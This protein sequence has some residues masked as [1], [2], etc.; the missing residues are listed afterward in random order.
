L[1]SPKS[2]GRRSTIIIIMRATLHDPAPNTYYEHWLG[3]KAA[4]SGPRIVGHCP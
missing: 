3:G 2:D 4:V 1:F